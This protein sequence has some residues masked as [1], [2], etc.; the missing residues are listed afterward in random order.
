MPERSVRRSFEICNHA[1]AAVVA[2]TLMFAVGA[3]AASAQG[4]TGTITGT[5]VG[6]AG[7]PLPGAQV[8]LVGTGLGTATNTNGKYTIVNVPAAQYRIRAQMIGHRPSRKSGH[9]HSRRDGDARLCPQAAG[10]RARRGGRHRHRGC[11]APA[12]GRERRESDQRRRRSK[13][14]RRISGNFCRGD[15]R[16][17]P[18]RK[19]RPRREAAR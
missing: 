17:P 10:G 15:R 14:R 11:G 8:G 18:S 6:E 9:C 5:V 1:I 13:N 16:A 2:F 19:A 12:R 7:Q 3:H 4:Q